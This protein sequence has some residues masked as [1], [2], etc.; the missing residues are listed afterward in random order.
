MGKRAERDAQHPEKT[1][2]AAIAFFS[3]GFFEAGSAGGGLGGDIEEVRW[4][5]R[6][7]LQRLDRCGGRRGGCEGQEALAHFSFGEL[8]SGVRGEAH[9]LR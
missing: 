5:S 2:G 8:R 1:L 6:D 9:L 7:L 4:Q 3:R